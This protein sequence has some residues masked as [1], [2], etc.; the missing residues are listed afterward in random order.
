MIVVH[1]CCGICE[2]GEVGGVQQKISMSG[3]NFYLEIRV[4]IYIFLKNFLNLKFRF[5]NF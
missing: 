3:F 1:L 2:M 5:L 4:G